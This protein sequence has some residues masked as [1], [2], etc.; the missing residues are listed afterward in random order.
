M[1]TLV[2]YVCHIVP[3]L[4]VGSDDDMITTMRATTMRTT[5]RTTKASTRDTVQGSLALNVR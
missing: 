4:P 2:T 1:V 5:M 3:F